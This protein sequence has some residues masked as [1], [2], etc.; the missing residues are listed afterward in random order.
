MTGIGHNSQVPLKSFVERIERLGEE[1]DALA[2][3]VKEIYSEAKGAGLKP[4]T[5]RKLIRLRK[6]SKE[7]RQAEEAELELYMQEMGMLD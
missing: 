4:K 3:D 5:L 2:E 7:D 1:Q 6:M